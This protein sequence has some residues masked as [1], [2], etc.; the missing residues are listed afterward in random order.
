LNFY[1][2]G[3]K[4]DLCDLS[5]NP[6]NYPKTQ[7]KGEK[8]TYYDTQFSK[9]RQLSIGENRSFLNCTQPAQ[10][11]LHNEFG[12]TH[13]LSITPAEVEQILATLNKKEL[14]TN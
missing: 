7:I 10:I 11:K 2:I 1:L 14:E 5:P 6:S 12:E 9:L 13:W 3:L 8:M 4:H